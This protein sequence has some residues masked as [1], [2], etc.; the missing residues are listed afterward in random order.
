MN[1]TVSV[2]VNVLCKL[3]GATGV[4]RYMA[5]RYFW[6]VLSLITPFT[7]GGQ[8]NSGLQRRPHPNPDL[9]LCSLTQQSGTKAVHRVKLL[10]RRGDY[11]GS[12]AGPNVVRGP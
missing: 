6:I 4:P 8:Q 7:C 10:V 12:S 9:Q 11:S 2:T 5:E 3:D 1:Y